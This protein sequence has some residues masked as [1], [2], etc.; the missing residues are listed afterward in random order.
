[1]LVAFLVAFLASAWVAFL[2]FV[3]CIERRPLL[4]SRTYAYYAYKGY[5]VVLQKG[6]KKYYYIYYYLIYSQ[7][8]GAPNY[9][10]SLSE[11]MHWN[12]H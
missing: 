1:M 8:L 10:F 11:V 4:T 9:L 12:H 2:A 5:P 7:K 6:Y 3:S